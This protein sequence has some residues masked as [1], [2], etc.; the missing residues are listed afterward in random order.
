MECI[1][2]E[3][4]LGTVKQNCDGHYEVHLPWTVSQ[5]LLPSNRNIAEKSLITMSKKLSEQGYL[6]AYE[7]ILKDWTHQG[8]IEEVPDYELE[9]SGHLIMLSYVRKVLPP[10]FDQYSMPMQRR[11]IHHP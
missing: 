4:F 1:V 2:K 6:K 10:H 11:E 9:N 3:H 8:I 5:T 7:D